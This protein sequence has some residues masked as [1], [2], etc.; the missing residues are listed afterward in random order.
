MIIGCA[1][2][3]QGLGEILAIEIEYQQFF[4]S[5]YHGR[6]SGGDAIRQERRRARHQR[7]RQHQPYSEGRF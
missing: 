3:E 5:A 4:D 1:R 2:I 7:R 6:V